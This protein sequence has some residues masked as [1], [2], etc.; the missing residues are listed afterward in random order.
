MGQ[1][2]LSDDAYRR[3]GVDTAAEE[4]SMTG[5]LSWVQRSFALRQGPGSVCLPIGYFANVIDLGGGQGLAI[6]T[7]G[8]G[9]KILIAEMLHRYDTIG[10]DLIAMNV[11][12]ILAV[13]AEPLSIVDYVAVQSA[14]PAMLSQ[15]GRGLYAGAQQARVTI[16]GGE[17]A[18]VREMIR[19]VHEGDA[20]DLVATAVGRVALDRIIVGQRIEEGDVVIGLASSGIHSNGLTLAREVLLRQ[21]GFALDQV[22]PELGR[23]LGDELLEPTRIYVPEVLEMLA[24]LDVHGLAHI[25]SDGLL[26]LLRVKAE[27]GY[28]IDYLP[29]PPAIFALIRRHG[30]VPLEQMYAVFNMG[31]GF[32]V[33]VPPEQADA[34]IAIASRHGTP[35]WRLGQAGRDP[36]R[37][38]RLVPAG[39]V[40]RG[41]RFE[42]TDDRSDVCS[43]PVAYS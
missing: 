10:I 22:I 41:N 15:L 34:V 4:Q 20:F 16:P 13:G 7:D 6:S 32:C 1:P 18:Q 42:S 21:A 30:N 27:V 33:T 17:I 29:A 14:D 31:I 39:L 2:P 8:V 3:A 35:A 43:P 36:E 19:G 12:D 40:G 23:C 25:T 5:L 26:N 9:T 24:T 38:V 37:R 11:N 28:V